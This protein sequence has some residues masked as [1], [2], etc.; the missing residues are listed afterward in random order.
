MIDG[1]E[2]ADKRNR[3][4]KPEPETRYS[5]HHPN[6]EQQ[7][8]SPIPRTGAEPHDLDWDDREYAGCEVQQETTHHRDEQE[9]AEP[10][11]VAG[12]QRELQ[13]EGV[14]VDRSARRRIAAVNAGKDR[15]VECREPIARSSGRVNVEGID[16]GERDVFAVLLPSRHTGLRCGHQADRVIARLKHHANAD[17]GLRAGNGTRIHR[18]RK[19]G[20]GF[21][22]KHGVVHRCSGERHL[23]DYRFRP[24]NE[25]DMRAQRA[26][27]CNLDMHRRGDVVLRIAQFRRRIRVVSVCMP[28]GLVFQHNGDNDIAARWHGCAVGLHD[29][30]DTISRITK[31]RGLL[32]DFKGVESRLRSGR[33]GEGQ[34]GGT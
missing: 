4:S 23:H 19:V 32:G 29:N 31:G 27:L 1:G 5:E 28:V 7:C 20:D 33:G 10:R 8:P 30:M 18:D 12:V 11:C 24:L 3:Q 26:A 6:A 25:R 9:Q 14:E 15:C 2:T 22:G 34:D 13:P 17:G 21:I 16:N